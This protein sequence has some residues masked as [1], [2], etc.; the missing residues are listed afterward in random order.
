MTV[1]HEGP[2]RVLE[3]LD[4]SPGESVSG[5]ALSSELSVSRAQIWKHVERLRGRGYTI[6]GERG[7]GYQLTGRPDRLYPEEIQ[8]G[9][10]TK[11]LGREIRY[12]QTTDSTNRVAFDLARAGAAHGTAVVAEGQTAG[13]GRLGRS[14]FSPPYLNLYTSIVLR[15]QLDTV[16]APTLIPAAGVAVAEAIAEQIGDREAVAI[17]WPN[18]VQLGGLKTSGILME[19]SAEATRVDFAILGIGVNLNVDRES[20]PEEFRDQATS[21]SSHTGRPVP[22]AVFVRRLYARL[23][24]VLDLHAR[25][26]FTALQPRYEARFAMKGQAIRVAEMGGRERHGTAHGIAKDG[27]LEIESEDGRIERIIAG[28]VTLVRPQEV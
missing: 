13:R 21:L 26:G 18:D 4:R 22:R 11:W 23:E 15:P 12:E 5:Q 2:T 19:M 20:F 1:A 25:Q 17:K 6:E 24:E 10:E 14:F 27:A 28:D 3:I 8:A 16:Q 7:G 9:L